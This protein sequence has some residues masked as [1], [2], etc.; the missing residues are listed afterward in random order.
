MASEIK[1]PE[2]STSEQ[3]KKAANKALG[4]G[5]A[6]AAAMVVQVTTLMWMRTTMNY[7]YKYGTG[8]T[9]ALTT[10]YA[11]G[12]I[13]RFYR[14]YVPAMLQAPTA[15]FGDAAAN[16]GCMAFLNSRE[17]TKNLPVGV[18]TVTSSFFASAFRIFLMPI[19]TVKT[20][21]QV[22]GKTGIAK[23]TAKMKTSGP[24][25][26]YHGSL[27][28]CAAT[29]VGHFPWFATYNY[30]DETLPHYDTKLKKLG[31][32]AIMGF[33]ASAVSDTIS[34][35]LR[36]VKVYR[37]TSDVPCGYLQATKNVIAADGL[38]GLFGRGLSTRIVANG[39]QG[40]MFS[41]AWKFLMEQWDKRQ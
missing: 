40:M 34:N 14:G 25:V 8:M 12:G 18:K 19:D 32:N 38:V 24:S 15:R 11:D 29:F 33:C 3:L 7:Q 2:L 35:S 13:L 27:G 17:D 10:L 36:V 31:R 26:L 21:M 6:G 20:I 41:V 23:L 16:V 9:T 1:K 22:E 39:C 37:Q 30:L 28:T 4:G 5:L